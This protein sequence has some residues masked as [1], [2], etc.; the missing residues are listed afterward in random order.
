MPTSD[1]FRTLRLAVIAAMFAA[2]IALVISPADP[3][4]SNLTVHPAWV[5][6]LVLGARHGARGLYSVPAIVAGVLLAEW[7]AGRTELAMLDQLTELHV[8]AVLG[9][10]VVLVGVGEGHQARQVR[11]EGRLRSA[12]ARAADA[13]VAVAALGEAAI[14]LRERSDR[15][16]TSLAFLSDVT[17]RMDDP[18][19]SVAAQ[20]VLE[21]AIARTGARGGFVQIIEG[22][23]LRTLVA[24]GAW[25][26]DQLMPPAV[27]RDRVAV[28]A[29]ARATL[30]AAHEVDAVSTEDSD[31]AAPL[32]SAGGTAMG[33][34][35]LRGLAY[36]ALTVAAREDLATITRWAGRSFARARCG[37]AALVNPIRGDGRAAT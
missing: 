28:A 21:L 1:R 6:A 27:F 36:P 8:L 19:P 26:A 9:V 7:V 37:A 25:S 30:C 32:L 24:Q 3:A 18:D 22:G 11:I 23:R 15:S 16:Q 33:V 13:E 31:L 4:M 10:I 35:A 12:E 20:A 29:L 5:I 17:L 34:L 2:M 14:A